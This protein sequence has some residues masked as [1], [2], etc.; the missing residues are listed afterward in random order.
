MYSFSRLHK[1]HNDLTR[2]FNMVHT[3][4]LGLVNSSDFVIRASQSMSAP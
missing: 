3:L 1:D 4:D 2:S